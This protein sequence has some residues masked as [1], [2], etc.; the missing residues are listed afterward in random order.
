MLKSRKNSKLVKITVLVCVVAM[1][2]STCIISAS[3]GNWS[4]TL[5]EHRTPT[6]MYLQ[7]SNTIFRAK[8][9][10]SSAY[11]Y[12][13]KSN[14]DIATVN[15]LGN[16]IESA[17]NYDVCNYGNAKNLPIGA[18]YYLPNTVKEEGYNYAALQMIPTTKL[19][20]YLYV[21]WSPDSI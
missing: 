5:H 1:I 13:Y 17:Y 11:A 14:T 7:F 20:A 4:D 19:N 15:V 3:A 8:Q 9:D 12:N 18:A 6:G 21:W 10:Y 2:I 16:S